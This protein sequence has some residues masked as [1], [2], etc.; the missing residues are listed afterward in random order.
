MRSFSTNTDLPLLGK[1]I[2][3]KCGAK[4]LFKFRAWLFS[5]YCIT[6]TVTSSFN[7]W[8]WRIGVTQIIVNEVSHV[9]FNLRLT[10]PLRGNIQKRTRSN[11]P[12]T[13]FR[14]NNGKRH[15]NSHSRIKSTVHLIRINI[16]LNP[17]LFMVGSFCF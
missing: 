9:F 8:L 5:L 17:S 13:F 10:L 2:F 14:Y 1:T 4:W 16:F 12:L 3:L 7:G 11:K 6:K 15:W